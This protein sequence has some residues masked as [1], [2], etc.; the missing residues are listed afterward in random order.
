MEAVAD[1]RARERVAVN[2]SR[3]YRVVIQGVFLGFVLCRR[4]HL[5]EV[6][7]SEYTSFDLE[8]DL[9]F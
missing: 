3:V 4:P 1:T 6:K 2:N 5:Y 8:V 7:S 9:R